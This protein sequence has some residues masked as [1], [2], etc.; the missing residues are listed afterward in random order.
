[1]VG[2]AG[3]WSAG[4]AVPTASKS[5]SEERVSPGVRSTEDRG[6]DFDTQVEHLHC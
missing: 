3:S 4:S 6:K 5:Q 2:I 1:M